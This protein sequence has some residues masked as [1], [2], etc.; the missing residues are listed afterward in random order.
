MEWF[1]EMKEQDMEAL[2][3]LFKIA[4]FPKPEEDDE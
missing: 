3:K 4:M 1:E 2:D